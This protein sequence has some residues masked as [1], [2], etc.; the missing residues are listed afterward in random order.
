MTAPAAAGQ[1]DEIRRE[2][3]RALGRFL[4]V[5]AYQIAESGLPGLTVGLLQD[6]V[7]RGGKRV[8]PLLCMLGWRAAG[9]SGLRDTVTE[10]AASLELFHAFAL[11]HDDVMDRSATRRG[12]PAVHRLVAEQHAARTDA[13]W[14]GTSTAILTGDF[15]LAWSAE[16][17]HSSGLTTEQLTAVL[18]LLDAMRD[19]VL[20]GQLLDLQA[21]TQ[22]VGD[23]RRALAVIHY[24]T[25]KYTVERPLHIGATLAGAGSEFR[26]RLSAYAIPLGEAYQLR[27][28]LLG[29]FGD[30]VVTG[31]PALDDLRDAKPTMLMSVAWRNADARQRQL[32]RE[33]V[34]SPGLSEQGA[35]AIRDV[36]VS[37]GAVDEIERLIAIRRREALQALDDAGF[38]ASD[39]LRHIAN[40]LTARAS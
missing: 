28:D 1:F 36:L 32:L 25:A 7:F 18:P 13:M 33:L 14:F 37:T 16:M 17:L 30:P 22:D 2:V 20:H 5:K 27:D 15:A 10:V 12:R 34:G 9:G 11:I 26:Q 3:D 40:T 8:R 24:K 23:D 31:K 21:T 39:P 29:V 6:F 4:A 19:E 38:P 35:D